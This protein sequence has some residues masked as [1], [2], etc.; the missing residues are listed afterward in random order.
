MASEGRRTRMRAAPAGTASGRRAAPN[1]KVA[2]RRASRGK[3]PSPGKG[4]KASMGRPMRLCP[5]GLQR[6]PLLIRYPRATKQRLRRN[7]R[8]RS[9]ERSGG[10][11]RAR[12]RAY[13]RAWSVTATGRVV[14]RVPSRV[15]LP[16]SLPV[17]DRAAPPLAPQSPYGWVGSAT[18][19]VIHE[20]SRPSEGCPP[21]LHNQQRAEANLDP[22]RRHAARVRILRSRRGHRSTVASIVAHGSQ[23]AKPDSSKPRLT[24]PTGGH[25]HAQIH[26][27]LLVYCRVREGNDRTSERPVRRS[28]GACRIA[29]RHA[30]SFLL[31]ARKA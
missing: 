14:G 8:A 19:P 13:S 15:L 6:S 10:K 30:G 25:P 2:Q 22:G 9:G 23:T 16:V 26:H 1:G 4:R 12:S 3:R 29:R 24:R 28:K 7:S 5:E 21:A 20:I 31:D 11:S 17:T 27:V 18:S